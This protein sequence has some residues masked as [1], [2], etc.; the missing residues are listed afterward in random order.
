MPKKLVQVS[1]R[2]KEKSRSLSL[3]KPSSTKALNSDPQ[4]QPELDAQLGSS[5]SDL[6][7]PKDLFGYKQFWQISPFRILDSNA[8]VASVEFRILHLIHENTQSWH[9]KCHFA[10][11]NLTEIQNVRRLWAFW[12]STTFEIHQMLQTRNIQM[13]FFFFFEWWNLLML[14]IKQTLMLQ[15]DLPKHIE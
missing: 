8:G 9:S 2:R 14:A 15:K 1:S 13:L 12:N 11:Q 10:M 4:T 5:T 6:D 3:P 7:L